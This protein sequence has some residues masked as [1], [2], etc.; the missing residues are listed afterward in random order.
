M[1]ARFQEIDRLTDSLPLE[2]IRS[3]DSVN[4]AGLSEK[5]LYRYRLLWI[6]SRDKSYI[7]HRSD[8]LILDVIDY[9]DRHRKE[10]LYPEALY[11]GGRVYSD[12][13]D[14][15]TALE[16]FQKSL[17]EIPEDDQHL[18]FR[19]IVLNQTGR[20]L[21][22]L[23]LDSE[24]IEYLEKSINA[25]DPSK[26]AYGITFTHTLMAGSF[27]GL[28]NNKLARKH[29]D[30]AVKLSSKLNESDRQTILSEFAQMLYKE[31]KL[32]SALLV[33]RPLPSTVDSFTI[34]FCL[35]V[36]ANIYKDTGILD[37]AYMYARRL[38]KLDTP[39][40]KKTGYKV[41]FS[42][43]L[44]C[45]VPKDT[46]L[47]LMPEYKQ[48]VED[49]L[50]THEAEQALIQNARYNYNTHVRAK[51]KAEEDYQSLRTTVI[52]IL[53]AIA[54]VVFLAVIWV[55][56]RKYRKTKNDSEV[57]KAMV[58]V[59]KLR[60][61][62]G[63]TETAATDEHSDIDSFEVSEDAKGIRQRIVDHIQRLKDSNPRSLIDRRFL[64]SN[65]YKELKDRIDSNE[66]IGNSD[67]ILKRLSELIE[68]VTPGFNNRLDILTEWTI[69]DR[70]RHVALLMR[71]GFSNSQI[72]TLLAKSK[73][74]IS[75]QRNAIAKKAGLTV[76]GINAAIASL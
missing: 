18:H 28:K 33:I 59:E 8:T 31:G 45:Y 21:Q 46:L 9:Y 5:D 30:E 66:C 50:D 48:T 72:S 39:Y 23:R 6:K 63:Q 13:G 73:S 3:L 62:T 14:L 55:L 51:E 60:E 58:F 11:Y 41:I 49:Y 38:T 68:T 20:L 2:A 15:P 35:A 4:T 34:P 43:E 64:D 16:F 67:D 74:T 25:G 29:I 26:D 1:D 12:L 32:D 37:T 22:T 54:A 10:G 65:V 76:N 40:N 57:M 47:K 24:A 71:C 27:R 19:N 75:S 52:V 36:A 70:E 69:S 61:K 53:G 7:T 42:D 56:W 17:N 44:S